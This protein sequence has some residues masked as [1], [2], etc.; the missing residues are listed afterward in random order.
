[1]SAT[2]NAAELLGL[3]DEIGTLEAGKL[4]DLIATRRNPLVD[5]SELQRVRFVMR[6][7]VV[8]LGP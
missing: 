4:A 7:G 8:V 5:I 3:E 6:E 1:V 2:R